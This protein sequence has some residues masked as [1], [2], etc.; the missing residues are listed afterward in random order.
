[1]GRRAEGHMGFVVHA[2]RPCTAGNDKSCVCVCACSV[3]VRCQLFFW[4]AFLRMF[5]REVMVISRL[6][7]GYLHF[8]IRLKTGP[9]RDQTQNLALV[10]GGSCTQY[11]VV[12][13]RTPPSPLSCP[14]P[15]KTV[16]CHPL[17]D[18]C[19][20]TVTCC[21][22]CHVGNPLGHETGYCLRAPECVCLCVCCLSG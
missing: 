6:N 3:C 2:H 22:C 17:G 11:G 18:G 13:W 16:P 20:M 10:Q 21:H 14:I 12:P 19:Q 8:G 1:M 7:L 4:F 9:G 5:L 15:A